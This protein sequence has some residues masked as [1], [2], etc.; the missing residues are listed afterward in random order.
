MDKKAKL[1]LIKT[2]WSNGWRSNNA[3]NSLAN[4]FITDD[5]YQY[6]VN[7]GYLFSS[8]LTF[9]HDEIILLA[10]DLWMRLG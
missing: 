9:G 4:N 6:C 5:E 10:K 3:L 7:N 2:F 1:V 8:S